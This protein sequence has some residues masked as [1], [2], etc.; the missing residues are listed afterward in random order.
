MGASSVKAPTCE[1]ATRTVTVTFSPGVSAPPEGE[2][3]TKGG[4]PVLT[5]GNDECVCSRSA[6]AAAGDSRPAL[7]QP[8]APA[9][10][11]AA[12]DE[13]EDDGRDDD[14][15]LEVEL[16]IAGLGALFVLLLEL[17]AGL[18]P[19]GNG[20]A[21]AG[22]VTT[23]LSGASLVLV[24]VTVW[25]YA[26]VAGASGLTVMRAP[27]STVCCD[28]V[29]L[30]GT[31]RA[32]TTRC[33][34]GY[35]PAAAAARAAASAP[36]P[37]PELAVTP[38]GAGSP[39][40]TSGSGNCSVSPC[41]VGVSVTAPTGETRCAGSS[42]SHTRAFRSSAREMRPPRREPERPTET[43]PGRDSVGVLGESRDA[44]P[45]GVPTSL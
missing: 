39:G 44:E 21:L 2:N 23:H 27:K 24:N 7:L 13:D 14:L 9:A 45:P 36:A 4:R 37:A 6:A 25:V 32:D 11:T 41:C 15:T 40:T 42:S 31:V 28:N 34:G 35:D 12:E 1:G 8:A 43:E 30:G 19:A 33:S 20:S 22:V 5:G 38:A 18:S 16:L 10:V 3:W 29:T 17:E 26:A